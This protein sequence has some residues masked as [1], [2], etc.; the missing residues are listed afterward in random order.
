VLTLVVPILIEP[1]RGCFASNPLDCPNDG[2]NCQE[3]QV[4]ARGPPLTAVRAGEGV[5]PVTDSGE[6]N[7]LKAFVPVE[8]LE[9][10]SGTDPALAVNYPGTAGAGIP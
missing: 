4:A 8:M 2:G 7:E 5:L 9:E 10:E 3:A 1:F 6:R